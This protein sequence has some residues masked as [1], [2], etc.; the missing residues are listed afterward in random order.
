VV[1]VYKVQRLGYST[2]EHSHKPPHNPQYIPMPGTPSL[3]H[4][5]IKSIHARDLLLSEDVA[6]E[7]SCASSDLNILYV[8]ILDIRT[9]VEVLKFS[10]GIVCHIIFHP[11]TQWLRETMLVM[12]WLRHG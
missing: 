2:D 3:F 12:A 11:K 10:N 9:E 1:I 7:S 8:E 5:R 4:G 6:C